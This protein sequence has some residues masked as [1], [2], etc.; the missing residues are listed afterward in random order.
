MT[1]SRDLPPRVQS[2]PVGEQQHTI[3]NKVAVRKSQSSIAVDIEQW[4][5]LRGLVSQIRP[6]E[7]TWLTGLSASFAAFVAFL[8]GATQV[9]PV[10]DFV[11]TLFWMATAGAAVGSV[12]CL[13]G[14]WADRKHR[15]SGVSSALN[16]MDSVRKMYDENL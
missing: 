11:A 10:S 2:T 6:G 14:F 8:I 9:G 16:Y 12:I 1:S 7:Q 3:L 5:H 4:E 13:Y 15:A